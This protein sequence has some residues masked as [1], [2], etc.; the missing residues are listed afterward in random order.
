MRASFLNVIVKTALKRKG[1]V[2]LDKRSPVSTVKQNAATAFQ[3]AC[4]K[5]KPNTPLRETQAKHYPLPTKCWTGSG[6]SDRFQRNTL[7]GSRGESDTLLIGS[8][9]RTSVKEKTTYHTPRGGNGK[10]LQPTVIVITSSKITRKRKK[11]DPYFHFLH[12]ILY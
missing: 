6:Y 3:P 5:G 2:T 9:T 4:A 11:S 10:P 8:Q 7:V 12:L 1:R